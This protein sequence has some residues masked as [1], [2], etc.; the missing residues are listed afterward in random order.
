MRLTQIFFKSISDLI[1]WQIIKLALIVGISLSIGWFILGF[2]FWDNIFNLI[3]VLINWVPFSVLKST[4][5]FMIGAFGWI[6]LVLITY[7]LI[8]AFFNVP[9]FSKLNP[10]NYEKFNLILIVLISIFWSLIT[11]LNWGFVYNKLSLMLTWFPYQ[12]LE[13]IFASMVTFL[14]FY[15][16]FIVSLYIFVLIFNKSFLDTIILK[17]YEKNRVFKDTNLVKNL[18]FSKK[19]II[20]FIALFLAFPLLFMPFVNILVQLF[21]W[22]YLVKDVYFIS[23]ARYYLDKE[24]IHKLNS[25]S[26]YKWV[27]SILSSML[28]LVPVINIFAPFL[29]QTFYLHWIMQEQEK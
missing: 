28:N 5:S 2:L 20:Y 26:F 1:N 9:I 17:D 29:A 27:I 21:L 8:I 22:A 16:L 4:L 25:K 12:T 18:S 23:V 15:N 3:I 7:A 24:Q 14:I 10:K 6:L 11:F 13:E 19:I